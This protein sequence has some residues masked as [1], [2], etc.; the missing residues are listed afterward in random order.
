MGHRVVLRVVGLCL[1]IGVGLVTACGARKLGGSADANVYELGCEN[2]S[3]PVGMACVTYGEGP[4]C[5]PDAERDDVPDDTDNCPYLA[6]PD[7][8]DLNDNT[9][10]DRCDLCP[11]SVITPRCGLSCCR[12]HDGDGRY[13]DLVAGSVLIGEDNCPYV[14]NPDQ[15]DTDGDGVGDACDACPEEPDF[16]PACGN[17]CLDTDGDGAL[18]FG[19]CVGAPTDPCV[20]APD[21]ELCDPAGVPASG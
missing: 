11:D 16:P 6:N 13:G 20:L 3:C 8:A 21:V 7:Q 5:L 17:G 4:W 15:L 10:G 14:A 18:D 1:C 9:V 2:L 12:D 19:H